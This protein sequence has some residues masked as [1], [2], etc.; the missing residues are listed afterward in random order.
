M[1]KTKCSEKRSFTVNVK[2][3]LWE[4]L[5]YFFYQILKVHQLANARHDQQVHELYLYETSFVVFNHPNTNGST[6]Q[7]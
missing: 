1:I 7:H 2:I 5:F 4:S 3:S 6:Q